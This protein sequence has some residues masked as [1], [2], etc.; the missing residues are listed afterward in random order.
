MT[1]Q[2]RE[3]LLS[4]VDPEFRMSEYCR[5]VK[6]ITKLSVAENILLHDELFKDLPVLS[7]STAKYTDSRGDEN[8]RKWTLDLLEGIGIKNWDPKN[9]WGTAGVSAA[10]EALAFCLFRTSVRNKVFIPQPCWQGFDWCFNQRP[11]KGKVIKFPTKK[12]QI[13]WKDVE[14]AIKGKP[15]A[16]LLVLT[17][18][19]NPLSINYNKDNLEE[20]YSNILRR[21]PKMHI[22]SD[23][24]YAFSQH[25]DV[26]PKFVSAFA[27]NAYKGATPE[28]KERVHVVWG[29]AKDLGLS[30]F[31]AGVILST[32]GEVKRRLDGDT[33]NTGWKSDT[34][35]TPIDSLKHF[36]LHHMLRPGK[37]NTPSIAQKALKKYPGKLKDAY[38]KVAAALEEN[39]SRTYPAIPYLAH[40]KAAQFFW[41]DLSHWLKQVDHKCD[42]RMYRFRREYPLELK[43]ECYLRETLKVTL[44]P[45]GELAAVDSEGKPK[46]GMFRLCY[47]A[48][49]E[50]KVV[51]AIRRIRQALGK[52]PAQDV[53]ARPAGR[54]SALAGDGRRDGS[55]SATSRSEA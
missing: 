52:L 46:D 31:K 55:S 51:K 39:H 8:F 37:N 50:K 23:E 32:N 16:R 25:D 45:G 44:L 35:L 21:Y 9:I 3:Y 10:L 36:Y 40:A 13:T 17:N 15:Y 48:E 22:I 42:L 14:K 33:K 54:G 1:P 27:L 47:T 26:E 43:M 2:N 19:H 53:T 18:P 20:I 49:E 12:P 41:I 11:P 6:G 38:N 5:L 24:I 28:Q 4:I 29:F 34:W 7:K 30:G